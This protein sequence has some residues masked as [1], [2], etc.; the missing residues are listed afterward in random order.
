M[1]RKPLVDFATPP[2]EYPLGNGRWIGKISGTPQ[3]P[4]RWLADSEQVADVS[5]GEQ[6]H[7]IDHFVER[8]AM[9]TDR[10]FDNPG[11][12]RSLG[13]ARSANHLALRT[14]LRV[15]VGRDLSFLGLCSS[16]AKVGIPT[17]MSL[18]VWAPPFLANGL[19][20]LRRLPRQGHSL[21]VDSPAGIGLGM[22]VY[23]GAV[24]RCIRVTR[25]R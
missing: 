9:M 15:G 16:A 10:F 17:P 4:K 21:K 25:S 13:V 8:P 23:R 2:T 5:H 14:A 18:G 24:P 1:G 7:G 12:S 6:L 11:K 19:L 22:N 20:W 3:A